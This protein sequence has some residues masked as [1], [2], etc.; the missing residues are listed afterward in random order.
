LDS[1]SRKGCNLN[2]FPLKVDLV[3]TTLSR[4]A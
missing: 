1:W 2:L 3:A 4:R